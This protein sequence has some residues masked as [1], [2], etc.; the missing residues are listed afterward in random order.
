MIVQCPGCASRYRVRAEKLPAAGGNIQCPNCR[1]IFPASHAPGDIDSPLRTLPGSGVRAKTPSIPPPVPPTVESDS[2]EPF[3]RIDTASGSTSAGHTWKIRTPVGLV[4]DFPNINALKGWLGTRENVDGMVAST[5]DGKTWHDIRNYAKLESTL[6]ASLGRGRPEMSLASADTAVAEAMDA[7]LASR[8]ATI[9][10]SNPP[11]VEKPDS[12]AVSKPAPRRPE[13]STILEKPRRSPP[14]VPGLEPGKPGPRPTARRP[15]PSAR[16][17]PRP[18]L[19]RG[20]PATTPKSAGVGTYVGLL[21]CMLVITAGVLQLTG[22][23]DVA[24]VL[25]LRKTPPAATNTQRSEQ[26]AATD[27]S[28]ESTPVDENVL[29]ETQ[30]ELVGSFASDSDYLVTATQFGT[31][32]QLG[33]DNTQFGQDAPSQDSAQLA[34]RRIDPHEARITVLVNR[35]VETAQR[36][37]IGEAIQLVSGAAQISPNNPD[38]VCLLSQLHRRNGAT[39][40]AEALSQQ[41]LTLRS[42]QDTGS[43]DGNPEERFGMH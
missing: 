11:L 6:P 20:K 26:T 42:E 31:N 18:S 13:A 10:A 2:S 35:A 29:V 22:A 38:L 30:P 33:V 34:A 7:V 41:C 5:D 32:T 17:G 25:G 15:G 12:P 28:Q 14:L 23:V 16:P 39:V 27:E 1:S 3:S 36:G 40:E 4:Y 24:G 21:V 43:P 9:P 37:N 8:G 19:R